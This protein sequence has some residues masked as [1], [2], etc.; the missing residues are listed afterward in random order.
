MRAASAQV[1]AALAGV[2]VAGLAE[3]AAQDVERGRAALRRAD[4]L[5]AECR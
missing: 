2:Q 4:A 3:A 1:N 5:V